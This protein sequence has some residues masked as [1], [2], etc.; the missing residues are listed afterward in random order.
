MCENPVK[1]YN[2][3]NKGFL[4]VGYDA[5]ITIIDMKLKK[6]L[7]GHKMQSKCGRRAFE[8]EQITGSPI[9]TIVNGNIVY[10]D[11]KIIDTIKGKPV[12]FNE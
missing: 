10:K 6:I 3:K 5:D 9:I 1:I 11:G 7:S 4:K 8:G 2:I 12:K